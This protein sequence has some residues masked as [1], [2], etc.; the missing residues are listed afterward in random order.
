VLLFFGMIKP[1]KGIEYLIEAMPAVLAARPDARLV[2]AG[3]PLM[4]LGSI[5][6]LITRLGVEHAII[7]RPAF[8]PSSDVP[9]YFAAADL[10]VAPHVGQ[11]GVSGVIVLSQSWGLPVVTTDVGG[12]PEL[13]TPDDCGWVVPP[14]QPRALAA[15]LVQAIADPGHLAEMGRRARS[16]LAREADWRLVAQRTTVVYQTCRPAVAAA[17]T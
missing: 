16:R 12:L 7:W 11:V 17:A 8:I 14:R 10:L 15:A 3:E 1:Y 13:V 5:R 2:I 9:R 6:H 4:S